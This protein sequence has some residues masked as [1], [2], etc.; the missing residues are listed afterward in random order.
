M[1]SP[2][3][4]F[5]SLT[6]L[7]A[8]VWALSAAA[9][10]E[11]AA[12]AAAHSALLQER[13]QMRAQAR[14]EIAQQRLQIEARKLEA[15]KACWQRFAVE[16][17]LRDVRAQ[18]REQDNVLRTRELDIS[19]EER[20]EKTAERLRAIEQKKAEKQAPGPVTA[21]PRGEAP[22]QMR[23]QV[24]GSN[25]PAPAKTPEDIAQAQAERDAQARE[26]AQQTQSRVEQQQLQA[27]QQ[28]A[29]DAQRRARLKKE[30]LAKQKAAQERRE[31]QADEIANRKGAPLP[32]PENL[33]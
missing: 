16:G 11:S 26:R 7:A 20:Q 27:A 24:D 6:V 12:D 28:E 9:Q 1:K 18:A 29:A 33:Q 13:A 4:S 19:S 10:P 17:C 23:P 8:S 32:V 15:E 5:R 3:V 21:T 25:V 14:S 31:R 30:M 2:C 22:L